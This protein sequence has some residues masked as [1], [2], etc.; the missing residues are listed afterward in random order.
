M[1]RPICSAI[2]RLHLSK[3]QPEDGTTNRAETC[4]W[5]YNLIKHKVVSV[6][7]IYIL[8]FRIFTHKFN[9]FLEKTYQML[10]NKT[11]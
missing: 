9:S 6:C 8:Y 5:K 4:R 1:F 10:K 7:I 3:D 11:N 2:F